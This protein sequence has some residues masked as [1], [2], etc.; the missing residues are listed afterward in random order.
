MRRWRVA[1]LTLCGGWLM[2]AGPACA[3]EVDTALEL[4]W[5]RASPA[6]FSRLVVDDA[7]EVRM[8]AARALGALQD[9][10]A[11]EWLQALVADAD[12]AVRRAAGAALGW[13]PGSAPTLRGLLA[14]T[15]PTP[16]WSPAR[17]EQEARDGERPVWLRALGRAGEGA[18][19]ALLTEALHGTWP[20]R[21]A[22]A[23]ALGRLSRRG[24]AGV[25]A[26]A[27]ALL[28]CA[29][30]PDRRV[31]EPCAWALSRAGP[32]D[33]D[34]ASAAAALVRSV[35]SEPA[36]AWLLRAAWTGL[37]RADRLALFVAA[38]KSG[39]R[40]PSVA[41]LDAVTGDEVPAELIVAYTVHP[42]PWIRTAAVAA[43]G[44]VGGEVAE[45]ALKH[46]G[47]RGD[48]WEAAAVIDAAGTIDAAAAADRTV[49]V[50][51][52]AALVANSR[53]RDA[54]V[55]LLADPEPAVRSAA[56]EGLAA[57]DPAP[58]SSWITALEHTDVAVREAAV[59][60][61]RA[62]D[63]PEVEAALLALAVREPDGEVLR[64]AL[65]LLGRAARTRPAAWPAARVASA[66]AAAAAS[67]SARARRAGAAL[68]EATGAPQSLAAAPTTHTLPGPDGRPLSVPIH[69]PEWTTV[70]RL[71]SAVVETERGR[72]VIDLAPEDAPFAVWNFAVL[73]DAGF[74]DGRPVH[75]LVPGFVAQTGCPRGDGW[76]GPG[77]TIPDE[78]TDRPFEV[79]SV[80]MARG[81]A[82]TGGSQWFVTLADTPQLDGEYTR[83]GRVTQGMDVVLRLERGDTVTR[84]RVERSP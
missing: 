52:R 2:A 33:A 37:G 73:A 29:A 56:L 43:L 67:P 34:A 30:D 7:P 55:A 39:G 3:G 44:R 24:V 42:D 57:L 51:M 31:A 50:P 14:R 59:D 32:L 5:S 62:V 53:D 9:P 27:P 12:P 46:L 61:L 81:D 40:L 58:V 84:V 20:E 69:P 41:A 76:G 45:D 77:W 1:A 6:A 18:D 54:L 38:I 11:L 8:A 25:G 66:L 74:F 15:P 17:R 78:R 63:A 68:A 22:A 4:G 47:E 80:G 82:D 70:G 65:D 79:G 35:A 83:F 75:R 10:A 72:F 23:A 26:A 49:P 21:A 13:T 48:A 19:V 16:G 64:A 28:R 71:R 36:R 60:A